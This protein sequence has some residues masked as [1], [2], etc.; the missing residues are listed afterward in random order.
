M[1][2]RVVLAATWLFATVVATAVGFTATTTVGDV[3]RGTGPL[4]PAYVAEN[5]DSAPPTST[6]QAP[7]VRRT[8]VYPAVELVVECTDRAAR[9]IRT[10]PAQGWTFLDQDDGPD[11]DVHVTVTQGDARTI[12][13]V[14][15]NEG[16]PRP[17]VIE[18]ASIDR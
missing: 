9:M 4:G 8:F 18:H 12:V 13:E 14:Y 3:L 2:Q 15:C 17:V 11:E 10:S 1:R 5:T 6:A 7:T 16:E